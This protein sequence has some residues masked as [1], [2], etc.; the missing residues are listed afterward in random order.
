[1]KTRG[2]VFIEAGTCFQQ[3]P[4][5]RL[6]HR[7]NYLRVNVGARRDDFHFHSSPERIEQGLH[8]ESV[9]NE[10]SVRDPNVATSGSDRDQ[11]HQ[12]S[13]VRAFAGRTL[14]DLAHV[15]TGR[16]QFWKIL[17]TVEQ[18]R[19]RLEPVID[20]RL[21][22]LRDGRTFQTIMRITPAT[23]G[24]PVALPVVRDPRPAEVTSPSINDE[25]L[26]MCA[27]IDCHIDEPEDFQLHTG[28]AEQVHRAAMKAIATESILQKVHFHSGPGAFRQRFGK[29]IRH[30][31]P[32][33]EEVLERDRPLRRT[34]R[35][36]QSGKNLI[37]I[38]E[39]GH[40]VA[41]Q[42]G[43]PEQI[44]HRPHEDVVPDRI[45]RDDFVMNF[46]F[47]RKEIASEKERGRSANS[48]RA[49]HLRPSWWAGATK[50][51]LHARISHTSP[52]W[53]PG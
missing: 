21:L 38:F 30:F 4:P 36:E 42:Q 39:G 28:L 9:R 43:R 6:A 37:A 53:F 29:C 45:V 18:L 27:E 1:V 8:A 16:F 10:V 31:A 2:L 49:E 48:G 5:T 33:E 51:T 17:V 23:R 24:A 34:D 15:V 13:A 25:Q 50:M 41:F 20:E 52:D 47:C 26:A 7:T 40:F 46:L 14:E 35:L 44:S 12:P 32:S 22:H 3:S 11:Q 19:A